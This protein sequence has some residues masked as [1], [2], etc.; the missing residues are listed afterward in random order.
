MNKSIGFHVNMGIIKKKKQQKTERMNK[1]QRSIDWYSRVY[2]DKRC[3]GWR[4]RMAH[5][6]HVFSDN[7]AQ[8]CATLLYT[9]S[10]QMTHN[11]ALCARR[12]HGSQFETRT[13]NAPM[14]SQ[15]ISA[16]IV[17]L[18]VSCLLLVHSELFPFI[19]VDSALCAVANTRKIIESKWNGILWAKRMLRSL[20]FVK[21]REQNCRITSAALMRL[22]L[23]YMYVVWD[24][25]AEP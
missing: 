16:C 15:S 10:D 5:L 11:Q 19:S 23:K 17:A 22:Y 1:Y 21:W 8:R 2:T 14:L 24:H 20:T 18:L 9:R 6:L 7:A 13:T 3:D 25:I 4:L 12:A